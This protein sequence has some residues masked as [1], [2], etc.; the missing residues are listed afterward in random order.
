M[1]KSMDEW[2]IKQAR[3]EVQS[4][5]IHDREQDEEGEQGAVRK[6]IFSFQTFLGGKIQEGRL[7]GYKNTSVI[8]I[9]AYPLC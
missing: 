9:Q 1:A 2:M 6:N 3:E 5:A 8:H 7:E 4:H